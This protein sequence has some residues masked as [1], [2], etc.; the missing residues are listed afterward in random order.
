MNLFIIAKEQGHTGRQAW[1]GHGCGHGGGL[2]DG[3]GR[4]A[5]ALGVLSNQRCRYLVGSNRDRERE[6]YLPAIMQDARGQ[7]LAKGDKV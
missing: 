2:G 6:R 7:S 5:G 1:C 3:P 4:C